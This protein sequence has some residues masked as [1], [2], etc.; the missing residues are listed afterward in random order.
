MARLPY[1]KRDDLGPAGRVIYDQLWEGMRK[2]PTVGK[3][4]G[5]EGT[6]ALLLNNPELAARIGPV[7]DYLLTQSGIELDVK[8]IVCLAVARELNCQ[9]EWTLHEPMA[10][11]AG[12]REHVIQGIKARNLKGFLP[13]ERVFVDYSW[14]VLRNKVKDSTWQAIDHLMGPKVA[15]NLT[16]LVSFTALISFCMDAFKDDL[17]VGAQPLLPIP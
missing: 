3:K 17:P 14:E 6:Y 9:L 7:G 1:L 16:M 8:E 11:A 5:I 10:R 4:Q 12:V 13:K 2:R 15:V